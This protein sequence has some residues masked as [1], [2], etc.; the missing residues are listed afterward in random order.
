MPATKGARDG[1]HDEVSR[2]ALAHGPRVNAI[3][4]GWIKTAWG[5][6]T[7]SPWLSS[8]CSRE[9]PLNVGA[10]RRTSRRRRASWSVPPP[11]SSRARSSASTA[12][13]SDNGPSAF[14]EPR[15]GPPPVLVRDRTIGRVR[16]APGARRGHGRR[17]DFDAEVTVLPI[18]V[19]AL[20]T[21]VWVARQL[22]VPEGVAR[23]VLPGHCRGD[24]SS[25]VEKAGTA[26]ALGPEDLR[27]LPRYFR[28]GG[29][30]TRTGY[31]LRTSKF[32]P[33][34]T[35][36]PRLPLAEAR[37]A[38]TAVAAEGADRIDLGC[39]PDGPWQGSGRCRFGGS[40]DQ[41]LRVSVG[42]RSHRGPARGP[43][44]RTSC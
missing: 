2:Q 41:G 30:S 13:R 18:S 31:A 44:W 20:M 42:V 3:A 23:V 22:E 27:D 39:G 14:G 34:S 21:P 9:T 6:Y 11:R 17:A 1:L 35:A 12:A 36:A 15:G 28:N 24:L 33:R 4:P 26:V 32:S 25:L 10:R 37:H 43:R 19:A 7:S 5:E 8:A 16:P 38:G 40:R 29:A